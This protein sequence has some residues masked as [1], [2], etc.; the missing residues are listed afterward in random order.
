MCQGWICATNRAEPLADFPPFDCHVRLLHLVKEID[1]ERERGNAAVSYEPVLLSIQNLIIP[2]ACDQN[3]S[4]MT[5]QG[6]LC[7]A[8]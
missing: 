5:A 1:A 4:S 6:A 3:N 8:P 7:R 2:F